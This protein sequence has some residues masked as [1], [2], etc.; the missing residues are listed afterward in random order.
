MTSKIGVFVLGSKLDVSE[1]SYTLILKKVLI[2][3][4]FRNKY[5]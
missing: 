2:L 4:K 1:N 3:F 5:Y